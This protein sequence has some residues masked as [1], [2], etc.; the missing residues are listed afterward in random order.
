MRAIEK[1]IRKYQKITGNDPSYKTW[2]NLLRELEINPSANTDLLG[3]FDYLRKIRNTV[4]HPDQRLNQTEAESF[5]IQAIHI[6]KI[7]HS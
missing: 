7:I 3:Y 6:F 4:Q 1:A 2:G 5:F